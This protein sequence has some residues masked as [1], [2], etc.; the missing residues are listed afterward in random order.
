[1]Q[2]DPAMLP[3][4]AWAGEQLL[5]NDKAVGQAWGSSM[6]AWSAPVTRAGFGAHAF[7]KHTK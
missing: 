2:S 3:E 5:S 4:G 1:M 7:Q 6:E